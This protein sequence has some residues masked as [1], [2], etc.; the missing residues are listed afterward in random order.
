[1]ADS[2]ES[3]EMFVSVTGASE[4]VAKKKLAEAGGDVQQ[5]ILNFVE[6]EEGVSLAPATSTTSAAPAA[7]HGESVNSIMD[8]VK[9]SV[10]DSAKGSG[11]GKD[12]SGKV[13]GQSRVVGVVFF[14]DGFMVDE[15][16]ELGK[17]DKEEEEEED[18]PKA[19]QPP[20]RGLRM[21]SL[22]DLSRN[23]KGKGMP[24]LPKKIPTLAPLRSYDE[25][26]NKEFL[27]DVKAGRVPKELQKRDE[28]GQPIRLT[29][30]VADERPHTYAELQKAL[31][32]M[33]M[34][35][36]KA[37]AEQKKSAPPGPALFTGS[38]QTL[39]SS[40]STAAAS[41]AGS[42]SC[43]PTLLALVK[44]GAP[45]VA[46]ESKPTTT[47]QLRLSTGVR[48]KAKLNLDHT[49]ADLWRLVAK[50]IGEEKFATSSGHELKAGFPPKPLKDTSATLS[51]ADLA[52]AAVTHTCQ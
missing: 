6:E 10:A 25:P 22:D 17:A 5:A 13:D 52:N 8:S 45:P 33:R 51:A 12:D 18:K 49:V 40:A 2:A 32:M 31:D 29:I 48:V 30:S 43:D 36:E 14:A 34:M 47:L 44:A 37:E 26:Q 7:S 1:M 27:D 28:K 19:P 24:K 41:S 15:S 21:M 38:G 50:E 42:G 46:D 35:K 9:A 3:I 11:K 39:S 20:T 16:D 4:E 23:D